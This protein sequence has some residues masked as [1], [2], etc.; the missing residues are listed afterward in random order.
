MFLLYF[1][2][3]WKYF[4]LQ[5]ILRITSRNVTQLITNCTERDERK[6]KQLR[7]EHLPHFLVLSLEFYCESCE[8]RQTK[9]V[10]LLGTI[11]AFYIVFFI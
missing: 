5:S 11:N 8:L 4:Q 9:S 10:P 1:I 6:E 7:N 3:I 2:V